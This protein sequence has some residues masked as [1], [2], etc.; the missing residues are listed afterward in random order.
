MMKLGNTLIFL[1]ALPLL[2]LALLSAI[3]RRYGGALL[4][5]TT[6]EVAV[7]DP[8]YAAMPEEREIAR[9]LYCGLLRLQP[10]GIVAPDLASSWESLEQGRL[11]RFVLRDDITFSSAG[12][13]APEDVKFSI[14]RLLRST[15]PSPY[16]ALAAGI[17]G[18]GAFAAGR[19][20]TLRGVRCPGKG[21]VEIELEVPDPRFPESLTL[22]PFS[23]VA[24]AEKPVPE[25]AG[26]A[27]AGPFLLER[28]GRDGMIVLK[29]NL[30]F[31]RG[32]PYV[33]RVEYRASADQ[34]NL[35]LSF[36]YRGLHVIDSPTEEPLPQGGIESPERSLVYLRIN[37]SK[38]PLDKPENRRVLDSFIDRDSI[39]NVI[40]KGEARTVDGFVD[41]GL[42]APALAWKQPAPAP[43]ALQQP[44]P[45]T[46]PLRKMGRPLS[47]IYL[48][49]DSRRK[50]VA[51]RIQVNLLSAGIQVEP[52]GLSRNDLLRRLY[53][54]KYDLALLSTFERRR[55]LLP[56]ML[57][58]FQA[59]AE[60]EQPVSSY[61]GTQGDEGRLRELENAI[62]GRGDCLFL[63]SQNRFYLAKNTVRDLRVSEE[64]LLVLEDCW[65]RS[66]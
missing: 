38:P 29:P 54:K 28:W 25:A 31:H 23:V 8:I 5:G 1:L 22:L 59:E 26:P 37:R 20:S 61:G 12:E 15:P 6:G 55:F 62:A 65:L 33:D 39:V 42:F 19:E 49:G 35:L 51:E 27:G 53:E 2:C 66:P 52:R 16:R 34:Q 9:Q 11:F 56:D 40:L 44:I 43:P 41:P 36:Q 10:D 30:R 13:I 17:Q 7:L 21:I 14:E 50:L 63:Y 32:R 60:P 58:F 24:R 46:S 47:L 18:A 4:R 57:A 48:A 64:G 45:E 3:P